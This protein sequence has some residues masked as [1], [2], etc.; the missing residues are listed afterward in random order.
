MTLPHKQL[1]AAVAERA[2]IDRV[3]ALAVIVALSDEV[4]ATLKAGS[5]I[6]LPGIGKLKVS[7]RAA[8]EG[9]HPQTGEAIRIPASKTVRLAP[10]KQLKDA[11]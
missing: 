4:T 6:T 5:D 10:T 1:I 7:R 2:G 9:R 11:L 8:R 3:K